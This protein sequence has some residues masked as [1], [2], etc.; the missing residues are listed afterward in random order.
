MICKCCFQERKGAFFGWPI[1]Q[2]GVFEN[3]LQF[4]YKVFVIMSKTILVYIEISSSQK[5]YPDL[6]A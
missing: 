5:E 3:L 2:I 1:L 6:H 4:A